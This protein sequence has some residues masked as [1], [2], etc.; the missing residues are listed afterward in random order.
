MKEIVHFEP[1]TASRF[2]TY[3]EVGKKAYAQHYLHLWH[4]SN[5]AP[6]LMDSFTKAVLE[7][8]DTDANTALFII[9]YNRK[10]VGILKFTVNCELH[11]FSDKEALYLD[12][13]YIQNE[14]TGKGIGKKVLQFTMLRAKEYQKKVLWLDTMQNGPAL[15]F[16]FKNGFE[17]HSEKLLHFSGVLDEERPMFVL[18]KKV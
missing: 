2:H 6:Y 17:I 12:K 15:Q 16:Y 18:T 4:K 9:N 10:A 7:R 5:A 13:I 3:I 14:Y 8:E 1:L 11:P